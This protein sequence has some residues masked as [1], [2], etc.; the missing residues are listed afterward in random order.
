MTSRTRGQEDAFVNP[1]LVG[2]P[3]TWPTAIPGI[4]AHIQN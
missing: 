1:I 3:L 2:V 4:A